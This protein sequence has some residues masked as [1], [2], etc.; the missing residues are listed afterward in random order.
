VW[1]RFLLPLLSL[2]LAGYFAV[3]QLSKWPGRLRY[4]G[5]EDAAE[6]TQLSEMV[7]LRRGIQIYRAPSSGEF[8][9]TIYGPLCYLV[10]E[11][12]I[13]PRQPAYLPLRLLSMIATLGIAALAGFFVYRLT[14]SKLGTL[15]APM[16]LLG[17]A[18]VGR[19]G[20]S[21]R[22]DM[23]A[24]FLS[25]AGFIVFY[26]APHSRKAL[27]L[28][29]ALMLLSLFYKQQFI[30]A[31]AAI[32]LYLLIQ[33]QFRRASEFTL[34]MAL[35]AITLVVTFSFIIFP[36]QHFLLH[37]FT[38]NRL[39]FERDLVLPEIVMFV[40][41][42]FVP[43]LGAADFLD[44]HPNKLA[45][46]YGGIASGTYLLLLFSSGSG[47]DTNRCLEAAVILSCLMAARIATRDT[48]IAGV[49]WITAL[50]FTFVLVALL[51]SAFVVPK[52]RAE[53]FVEDRALQN[54][55]KS[56]FQPGTPALTYYAGDPIRAGLEAPITNLWHYS[57][58][59][60]KGA[61]SDHDIVSRIDSH[62]YGV[63]LLDFKLNLSNSATAGNFYTTRSMRDA[64]LRSYREAAQLELPTP[65]ITRF[66]SKTVHIWV[67]L[68]KTATGA[69]Q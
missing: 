58:L 28:A 35:G 2:S 57:S 26:T 68:A 39:P 55:L 13:N 7:H 47:A 6:G 22:A 15:L 45:A 40:V 10:G 9:G 56:N 16:L 32:F 65:E 29:T 18:Y 64:V 61:L 42:L 46:C 5:E 11:A 67:P 69:A 1:K 62:G 24:L 27:A 66:S 17:T 63:I 3:S 34:F 8:D 50:G 60:R 19:Y 14:Q 23:V 20:I 48:A 21:A 36:H 49:A 37:F 30:G 12:I 38:Y 41:P 59:I 25:F 52:V 53:D 44:H 51:S 31:P 43:L 54:F 33:K 4:S